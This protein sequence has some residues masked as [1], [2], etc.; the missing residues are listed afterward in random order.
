MVHESAWQFML[1]IGLIFRAFLLCFIS[2][3]TSGDLGI[4]GSALTAAGEYFVGE[5]TGW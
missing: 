4:P 1:K 5:Y 3:W 2:S